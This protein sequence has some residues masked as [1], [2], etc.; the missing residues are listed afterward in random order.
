VIGTD[1]RLHELRVLSGNPLLVPAA[2]DAVR[3]W[4]YRPG[5]L[6]GEPVEI[7]T[8]IKVNFTLR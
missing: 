1:G 4:V 2:M 7:V 5:R 8:P 6:N 3:H